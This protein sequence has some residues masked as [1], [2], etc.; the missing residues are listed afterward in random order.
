[1]V[2]VYVCTSPESLE[3]N[4]VGSNFVETYSDPF[5]APWPGTTDSN[6]AETEAQLQEK[7]AAEI[8]RL[9]QELKLQRVHSF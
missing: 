5:C 8:E 6:R 3:Q 9:Q 2:Y 1:M 7:N 4:Y